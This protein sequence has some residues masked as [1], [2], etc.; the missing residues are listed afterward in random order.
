MEHFVLRHT[1]VN[2]ETTKITEIDYHF[3]CHLHELQII[4][5]K[6]KELEY[7]K[8]SISKTSVHSYT[9]SDTIKILNFI[10]TIDFLNKT[11]SHNISIIEDNGE[12]IEVYKNTITDNEVTGLDIK[13]NV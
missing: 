11:I 4:I 5:D 6:C 8:N 1:T 9:V 10:D 7:L 12:V 2:I 3:I 13:L